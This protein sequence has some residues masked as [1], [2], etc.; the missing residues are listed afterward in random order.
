MSKIR[1]A[2]VLAVAA[3]VAACSEQASAPG[4]A[5]QGGN[6]TFQHSGMTYTFPMPAG[7]CLPT[8]KYLTRAEQVAASD[9]ANV[10]KLTLNDCVSMT[11]GGNLARWGMV[12]SPRSMESLDVGTRDNMIAEMKRQSASGT[13]QQALDQASAQ[14]GVAVK[15]KPLGTDYYGAYIGGTV[16]VEGHTFAGAWSMTVIK[17][18]VLGVYMYG[19]Y[20][21]ERDIMTVLD[22]VKEATR[23]FVLANPG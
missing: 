16:V 13:F 22:Q 20:S 2:A 9:P 4:Q 14:S 10:T 15:V 5:P 8:G 18:R 1:F 21:G 7:F 12:K 19:P 3:A 17:H 11:Q 23:N 6:A